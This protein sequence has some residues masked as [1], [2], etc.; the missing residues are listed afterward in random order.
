M[1][2]LLNSLIYD[3]KGATAVEYGLIVALIVLAII[4][5]ISSVAEKTNGMWN[6]VTDQVT[7]A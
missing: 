5:A 4:A 7:N 6:N 3:V 2:R 1:R